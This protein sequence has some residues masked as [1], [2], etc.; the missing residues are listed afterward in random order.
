M[1]VKIDTAEVFSTI[2]EQLQIVLGFL[3]VL[4]VVG[5]LL[6]RSR[7]MPLATRLVDAEARAR[8]K[9]IELERA[10][11]AKDRFLA[12]MSHELR[13]PLNAII[14]FTGTLLMELPGPVNSEQRKQLKTVQSSGRHLLA[15]IDDL[16]DLARIEAGKVAVELQ[17]IACD[18]VIEEVA[19][20][21]RPGALEKG[22]L[23]ELDAGPGPL[24][25]RADQRALRQILLNLVGN[26]IKF[27]PSGTV[28]LAVT[29]VQGGGTDRVRFA[30]TDTGIGI[31]AADQQRL[32]EP[33]AR[34]GT[35]A[36]RIQGTGLGLHLSR[37]LAELMGAAIT[38]E[39]QQG[40]GSTF[41]LELG[42]A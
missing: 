17:R 8:E 31:A 38:C 34:V 6:I 37:A 21:L 28:R 33:F 12:T 27:T 35:G 19:A 16:L 20:A 22:L 9:N 5:T 10:N 15:L 4:V 18:S 3:V 13:T 42:A 32:F 41:V 39:S 7:V 2:R 14:G 1:V 30:V 40:K 26:A 11:K 24:E 23:F 36:S 29:S 25:V